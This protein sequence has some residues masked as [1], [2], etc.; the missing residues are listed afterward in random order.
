MRTSCVKT[1][2]FRCVHDGVRRCAHSLTLQHV[3][4]MPTRRNVT[5]CVC[6]HIIFGGKHVSLSTM[7]RCYLYQHYCVRSTC[8][9]LFWAKGRRTPGT[10]SASVCR[11][12]MQPPLYSSMVDTR[13]KGTFEDLKHY[14]HRFYTRYIHG[15]MYYLVVQHGVR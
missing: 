6:Q 14:H 4:N 3:F 12:A 8:F 11:S 1:R 15:I 9:F 13:L 5:F 2:T 10:L 7:I